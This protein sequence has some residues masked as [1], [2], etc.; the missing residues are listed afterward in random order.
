MKEK[1]KWYIINKLG[2]KKYIN[3]MIKLK[4]H[5]KYKPMTYKQFLKY[6]EKQ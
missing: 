5:K 2:I 3:I 6:R 4:L 1:I